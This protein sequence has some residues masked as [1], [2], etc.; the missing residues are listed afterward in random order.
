MRRIFPCNKPRVGNFE[1][2]QTLL[3]IVLIMVVSLTVGLAVVSRSITNLRMTTEEENSTRA[4]S[5]AEAGIERVL[6]TGI[7]TTSVSGVAGALGSNPNSPLIKDIAITQSEGDQ[8]LVNGGEAVQKDD[9]VDIWLVKHDSNNKPVYSP[10]WNGTDLK[11]YWG[12]TFCNTNEVS[13]LEIIVISGTVPS[14]ISAARYAVDPCSSR[15]SLNNFSNISS[16]SYSVGGKQFRYE[17]EI[18][19]ITNGLLARVIPLYSSAVMGV[20]ADVSLP[21][22]GRIIDSTGSLGTIERKITFFQGYAKLP[23]EL[24][25]YTIFCA[26][27]TGDNT[28][29]K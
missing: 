3:I 18:T 25:Q 1:D 16:G 27:T 13:A 10:S 11:F 28:S 19:N 7:G 2:G 26:K 23:S 20:T 9:G 17:Y 6:K 24:F 21:S 29:C 22:Q 12:D 5:A 15:S 4:F 14:S 8:I